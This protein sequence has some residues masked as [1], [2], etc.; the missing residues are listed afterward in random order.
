MNELIRPGIL[1]KG[2]S[3]LLKYLKGQRL[4]ASEAIRAKCYDCTGG[5]KD[6]KFDC[7]VQNCSLYL[8]MPYKGINNVTEA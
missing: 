4:K 5:Y 2:R 8:F 7:G 6:G 1:A 3:E